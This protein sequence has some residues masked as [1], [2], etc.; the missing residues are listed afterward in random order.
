MGPSVHATICLGKHVEGRWRNR[1]FKRSGS[2]T[3]VLPAEPSQAA[4]LAAASSP[5]GDMPEP[6]LVR[7][8]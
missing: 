1:L 3:G 8:E 6:G 4:R 5:Y 7:E 2:P